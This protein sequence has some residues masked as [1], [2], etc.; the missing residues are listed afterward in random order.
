MH[1]PLGEYVAEYSRTHAHPIAAYDLKT[2]AADAAAIAKK[3]GWKLMS[4][5]PRETYY[6]EKK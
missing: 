3:N 4:V 6:Q 1:N 2:A 5:M